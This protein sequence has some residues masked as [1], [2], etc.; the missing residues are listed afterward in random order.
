MT[1]TTFETETVAVDRLI[2]RVLRRAHAAMEAQDSP[3]E[4][5]AVLYLAHAFADELATMDPGFDRLGFIKDAT[6]ERSLT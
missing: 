5:R 4:A 2:A 3:D 1:G 6:E